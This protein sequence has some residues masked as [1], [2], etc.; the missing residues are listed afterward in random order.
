MMI[1]NLFFTLLPFVP[2][3][4][5]V[6]FLFVVVHVLYRSLF[7]PPGFDREQDGH[8]AACGYALGSLEEQRCPECGVDLLKAGVLTRRMFLA[9][10]GS[11]AGAVAAWSVLLFSA[12]GMALAIWGSSVQN[13]YW[14]SN[15]F[16][17]G[18]GGGYTQVASYGPKTEWDE[19]ARAITGDVFTVRLELPVDPSTQ[20]LAGPLEVVLELPDGSEATLEIEEDG[21]WTLRGRDGKRVSKGDGLDAAVIDGLFAQGGF[22]PGEADIRLYSDQIYVLADS[23]RVE[24][25]SG[26]SSEG[27]LR[28][29]K[30]QQASAGRTGL[31]NSGWTTKAAP[32]AMTPAG[33]LGGIPF[34]MWSPV[35]YG[36]IALAA[37]YVLGVV[38][39]VR[40]R[41]KI[42]SL[43]RYT[44][45][46]LAG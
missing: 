19:R 42:L 5:L 33:P 22:D 37:V 30:V 1:G 26:L 7:V 41:R 20:L 16:G 27:N 13:A 24:G 2:A 34:S 14:M 29:M 31:E 36:F 6:V 40:R 9:L 11:T 8:C 44:E 17:T 3:S 35:L 32:T 25:V 46:R 38:W 39:I 23:A 43:G 4:M 45:V 18:M 15:S 21:A 28:M 10:R 12:G